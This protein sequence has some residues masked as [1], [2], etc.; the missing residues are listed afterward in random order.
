MTHPLLWA[1]ET[2]VERDVTSDE[3]RDA[4]VGY[5]RFRCA[6]AEELDRILG[7]HRRWLESEAR[8]GRRADPSHADLQGADL[9]DRD[10]Q[11]TG[12]SGADVLK[13]NR[14][15]ATTTRVDAR[16]V[17]ESRFAG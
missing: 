5:D 8:E 15:A 6:S 2:T 11:K 9:S 10:L 7:A 3:V 12:I 14:S 1:E 4:R 16:G 13:A 17:P